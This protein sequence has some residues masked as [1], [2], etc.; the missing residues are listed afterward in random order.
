LTAV[1]RAAAGPAH[2]DG[3]PGDEERAMLRSEDLWDDVLA[4]RASCPL[5]HNVTN[6]VVMNFTA[7][8]LLAAGASPVMAHARDEVEAMAALAGAVVL[9]IGTLQPDWVES[10]ALALRAARARR[11]PVVLDP[12]GVGATAYRRDAV[13]ALRAAG[14]PDVLRGNAAEISAVAGAAAAARGVD[15]L[16]AADTALA[17]ARGL[18]RDSGA[19]VCISGE[20]DH[21]V[22]S[23]GRHALLSN[24]HVWMT[25]VTGVGCGASALVGAFAA[26]Q[27]DRWRA[28]VAAMAY[29]GVAGE[30]AAER[31]IAAGGGVGS[32]QVALLDAVQLLDGDTFAARLRLEVA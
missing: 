1:K 3:F 10:M 26:V 31:T 16:D 17:A 7:N 23:A 21:V 27:P 28:T 5:V 12:V 14:E 25:R 24:G 30:L 18:S 6:L 11:T 9:N 8:L 22:D 29:L 2:N 32:F 13:R 4:L 15:S 20:H 19:V